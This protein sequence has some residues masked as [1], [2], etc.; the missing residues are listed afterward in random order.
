MFGRFC[1]VLHGHLPWV[2]HHGRWPHGE[3][4]LYE[5]A[6]ETWLPLLEVLRTCADEGIR[7]GWTVGLTPVLLEQL[8]HPRFREGLGRFLAERSGRA[9]EDAE[10]FRAQGDT[11]MVDLATAWATRY[12]ELA[13]SFAAADGDLIAQFVGHARAGRIEI[14]SSNATHGYHPL[15][16]HD[17]CGRA[18]VRAGLATSERHLGFRPRGVWLPECAYRPPGTWWPPAVHG[19]PR[20]VVGTGAILAEEGVRFFFVDTHLVRNGRA[21]ATVVGG[22]S[23][24]VDPLQPE[25]DVL[26]A[27]NNE[28]EPHRVVERG[29]LLPIDALARCPEVSEQVWS[30]KI[31]YPGDPRYLEFHKRHGLRGLRYW[32]VTSPEADLGDKERY[33]PLEVAGAVDA[34]AM[35][36]CELVKARLTMHGARTGRVGVVCAPFDAELFGHWWHEGPSFLLAVA[37]RMARDPE[38]SPSTVSEVLDTAPPDK[39]V[40]LPEGSWGAGGDHRVWLNDE[41]RFYWEVAYRAE[42]RF[43]DL[44]GRAPWRTEDDARTLLSEAARQLLL[45]QASDWPFVISTGGAVDYGLRRIFEHVS[46]FDDLCNG[47]EDRLARPELPPDPIVTAALARSRLLDPVF[48]DLDLAWWS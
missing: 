41:L 38:I 13:A 21:E 26:R 28:L 39:A 12:D 6:A 34:Q 4:W 48:P 23:I 42:D 46:L 17:V 2:L 37:R 45:L 8:A 35:H 14:L 7:P 20:E 3:D 19:L 25:W 16:L 44:L 10:A 32:R 33:R 29:A 31:G 22:R 18:Q 47:V 9:T 36:F 5:A 30:G 24:P 43:V 27:W 40:S 15:I 1:L 11:E